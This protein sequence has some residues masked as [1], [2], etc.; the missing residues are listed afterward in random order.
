[1]LNQIRPALVMVVL[2]TILTGLAYPLAM[3]GVS[4]ALLPDQAD[5][6]LVRR[7]DGTV[8]GSSLIGQEFT[9]DKYF[10]GRPSATAPTPY[11]AA[12]S[13][14]SNLGPTARALADRVKADVD[15]LAAQ[16]IETPPADMVT[17]SASG[18]DPDISPANAELQVARV[19]AAR[20]LPP[21]RVRQAVQDATSGRLFGLIGEPRVNVLQLNM[22]LDGLKTP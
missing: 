5:G 20:G 18:L 13:A 14:G 16:G 21:E 15:A 3:T 10:H 22:A 1:M 7:S 19:A 2:L 8:I 9:G 17:A 11:N 6:S 12:S 4:Q